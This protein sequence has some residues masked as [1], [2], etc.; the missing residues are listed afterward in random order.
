MT[1]DRIALMAAIRQLA[2][3]WRKKLTDTG[4]RNPTLYF[5]HLKVGTLLL[6]DVHTEGIVNLVDAGKPLDLTEVME[7]TPDSQKRL[8][9][10]RSKAKENEEERGIQT[11]FLAIGMA[12][13]KSA[14]GGT[15]PKAP[16][17][18]IPVTVSEP[19]KRATLN[20]AGDL[21]ANR[22]MLQAWEQDHRHKPIIFNN[23]DPGDVPI[24][25]ALGQMAD[26]GR[27]LEGF[28]ISAE[29]FLGNFS[30]AKMAMVEDLK[31]N[32]ALLALNRLICAIAGDRSSK[33]SILT[34]AGTVEREELDEIDPFNE[35][36][37][38]EADEYQRQAIHSL[39]RFDADGVIDGPPGTGKSQ[40]IAN[41]IAALVAAGK[42]V[43]FVAEKR[44]ALDAVRNRLLEAGL[45]DIVLD[46]HGADARRKTVYD[47]LRQRDDLARLVE[48]PPSSAPTKDLKQIRKKLNAYYRAINREMDGCRLSVRGIISRLGK[49]NP[50]AVATTL[51]YDDLDQLTA[52]LHERAREA[53][54][55]LAA[56]SKLFIREPGVPWSQSDFPTPAE[57]AGA[58]RF[59]TESRADIVSLG[60]LPIS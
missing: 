27:D 51:W 16:V 28:A 2:E 9:T 48:E 15:D 34:D 30:F 6:P 52:Q 19:A 33:D 20:R 54:E 7:W 17:F 31:Q 14:D 5:K 35:T 53:V 58:V 41:L 40:T 57:A 11:M 49:L 60:P 47:R 55:I 10:I 42:R 36:I 43:L 1:D 44:A 8:T 25:H 38:L 46:L 59:V 12:T 18:L 22:V 4:R 23:D 29:C 37:V 13:W 3:S 32:E 45:E 39:I 21:V 56:D 26:A 50:Q 24:I